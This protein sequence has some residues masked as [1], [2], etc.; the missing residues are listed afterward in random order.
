MPAHTHT[1]RL[2]QE[3]S[4]Y[5]LQHAHN[6]VDWNSWSEE[7]L[8]RAKR[9][10]RPIFL[11]VGYSTCYW[12]HVMERECFENDDI[13]A[14]MNR[15]FVC[16]KV[17]REERPDIDQLYMTALQVMTRQGGWP[18][19]VFLTPDLRPFFA[20]TYFPPEDSYG[21]PGFARILTAVEEAYQ[22]RSDEV[23]ASAEQVVAILR[24]MSRPRRGAAAI[25]ID[26]PFVRE[27][28]DRAAADFDDQNGGFGAAPKFPQQTLLEL[29]LIYLRDHSDAKL[30]DIVKKSLDAMAYGGI[31][32]HLGG[33]FHRY[34]TDARWL[35]PHFEIMLYD[36][37]MLLWSYAE[38]HRH[39]GEARYAA[40][41]RGIAD[42]VLSDM[43]APGGGFFTAL[44]AEVDAQEGASYLWTRQEAADALAD[45]SEAA[46]FLRVYGLDDGPNFADPHHGNGMPDK[47]VLYLAEPGDGS[48]LFDE[49]LGRL[50]QILLNVRRQRKQPMLDRKILTSWNALMIRGLAHAGSVLREERYVR[51]AQKAADFLWSSH[52]DAEGGL[53]RVSTGR[54]A[55]H[56]GF[57]DDYAFLIQALLIL[58]RREDAEQLARIMQER[59][60]SGPDGGFFYTDERASDLIVRQMIGSDSPLPSGNGV[61]AMALLELGQLQ[62]ARDTIA[63]FADQVQSVGQGMSALVEAA[64]LFVKDHGALETAAG[65]DRDRAP[66]PGELAA[67]VVE[68]ET[69][70]ESPVVLRVKCRVAE[71]F[72]L[73]AH[74]AVEVPTRLAAKGV[75]V[76]S[77]EY[78]AG[79]LRGRFE[80][81]MRLK[82]PVAGEFEL[83]LSYQACDASACLPMVTRRLKMSG[84]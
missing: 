69:S 82:S 68:I 1:N 57:L 42:F 84:D 64:Y 75:A 36:N 71:R 32:D 33:G 44:D 19:N 67:E 30:M 43:T 7:A 51:A 11:S 17:D 63:A 25:R 2:A 23:N 6:P 40:V 65:A 62:K 50:R 48:A 61:A 31:R 60:S 20:G 41:A 16:I 35:V 54:A 77:V 4:P 79:E 58:S 15:R 13:A 52:R 74:D 14:E 22:N 27:M 8:D 3:T 76:E 80:I 28:I 9:E 78:P 34:S 55:K 39:T 49:K 10:N 29:I 5:L 53:L 66:S 47:N 56:R 59:F 46:R 81:V 70:W 24:Q 26:H 83:A 73:N 21:R 37:A 38:A 18:M 12:C 45:D 72:H